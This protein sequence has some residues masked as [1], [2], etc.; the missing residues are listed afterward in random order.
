[1]KHTPQQLDDAWDALKKPENAAKSAQA[2]GALV[3]APKIV[4]DDEV[5]QVISLPT[6]DGTERDVYGRRPGGTWV[7]IP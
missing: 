6:N 1:M 2:E 4:V 7:P 5:A 3:P